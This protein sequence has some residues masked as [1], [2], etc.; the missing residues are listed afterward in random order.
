[1][2]ST[3][4]KDQFFTLILFLILA[5]L[6]FTTIVYARNAEAVSKEVYRQLSNLPVTAQNRCAVQVIVSYQP[7]INQT[8]VEEVLKDYDTCIKN[9]IDK[10]NSEGRR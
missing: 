10:A 5:V 6:T 4:I 8:Q 1:M 2:K 7:P 3:P 9:Q